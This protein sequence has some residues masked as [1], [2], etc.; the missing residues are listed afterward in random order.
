MYAGL[1]GGQTLFIT[2]TH[3]TNE[4]ERKIKEEGMKLELVYGSFFNKRRKKIYKS[5]KKNLVEIRVTFL[6]T[7]GCSL[8]EQPS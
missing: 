8:A 6:T 2:S 3:Q 5:L 4:K 1:E 7:Y